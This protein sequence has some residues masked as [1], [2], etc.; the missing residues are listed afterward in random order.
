MKTIL[1]CVLLGFM[2]ALL[3]CSPQ[4]ETV[5]LTATRIVISP[6]TET[7]TPLPASATE[8]PLPPTFT[9][10][11]ATLESSEMPAS[12]TATPPSE[13]AATQVP[14]D[15]LESF[16]QGSI[17]FLWNEA[18]PPAVDG[19]SEFEPTVSLYL[20]QPGS[21]PEEWDVQP[22]LTDLRALAPAYL[23]PDQTKVAFLNYDP[24]ASGVCMCDFYKIQ[25]YN[26][27]DGSLIQIDNALY[28]DTLS[29]L[30]DSQSLVFPQEKDVFVDGLDGSPSQPVTDNSASSDDWFEGQIGQLVGSPDGRFQA[31]NVYPY[32]LAIYNMESQETFQI[33]DE[34][35]R[36]HLTLEWSP[37][38][39]WLAFTRD[40]GL[41]LFVVDVS[42]FTVSELAIEPTS[43]YYPSWSP[44]GRW[45]AFTQSS[46][47]SLWDSETE[48]TQELTSAYYVGEP[49]WSPDGNSIAAG[50]AEEDRHGIV[51]LDP[52]NGD[53]Q[54]LILEM[55]PGTVF[56]D[57]NGEWLLFHAGQN[58][59]TG[60]YIVN[61]NGG[62]PYL[63]IDAT[64]KLHAPEYIT[65]LSREINLP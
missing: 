32:K 10:V 34:L 36:D 8:T 42:N 2:L 15:T 48:T 17:L 58:D 64:E 18:T 40:Y 27:I 45:L 46:R 50:F 6:T 35:G 1:P 24:E 11:P 53:R 21:T 62:S 60:L 41:S 23:S 65:W 5:Q 7:Q 13:P 26:L 51:I 22:L 25:V 52:I 63:I 19:P 54:E 14:T 3:G 43:I 30:P 39:Q 47:L 57:P 28:L 49:A 59:Q 56:W 12:A 55:I 33:A 16:T 20:A 31:L 44:D 61:R 4:Q 37:N 9:P 38:S 29:W